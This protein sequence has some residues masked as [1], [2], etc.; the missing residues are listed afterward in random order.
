MFDF[1]ILNFGKPL[2]STVKFSNSTSAKGTLNFENARVNWLY[3]LINQIYLKMLIPIHRK[4][5][6][7]DKII[8]LSNKFTDLH[9]K[10]YEYILKNKGFGL[11]DVKK[12]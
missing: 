5:F 3:Q 11:D 12:A 4:I 9:T 6:I 10:S 8:D 1:L 2:N 7:E